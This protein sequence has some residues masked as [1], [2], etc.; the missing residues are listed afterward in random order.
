MSS[1]PGIIFEAVGES[2]GRTR[3]T[4]VTVNCTSRGNYA[5]YKIRGRI[6]VF[7]LKETKQF[8]FF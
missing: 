6:E 5:Q 8:V 4:E 3:A 1:K 7:T 2:N